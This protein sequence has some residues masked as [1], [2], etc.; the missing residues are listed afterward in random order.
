[1]KNLV[2]FSISGTTQKEN[3]RPVPSVHQNVENH[4]FKGM[5]PLESMPATFLGQ[6]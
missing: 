5:K 4:W 3:Y 6:T 2:L 1:M